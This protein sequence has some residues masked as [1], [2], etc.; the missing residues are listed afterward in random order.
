[1]IQ[2][3]HSLDAVLSC[4]AAAVVEAGVVVEHGPPAE[5]LMMKGDDEKGGKEGVLRSMCL[6]AGL[7]V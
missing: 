2:V 5:L 6:A 1:M 4:D 7:A 3:A